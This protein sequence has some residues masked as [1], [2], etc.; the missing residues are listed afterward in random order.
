MTGSRDGSIGL[1]KLDN[2]TINEGIK[3]RQ[4]KTEN[5]SDSHTSNDLTGFQDMTY[6]SH[7]E[8]VTCKEGKKIRSIL[9][10]EQEGDIV[11]LTLNS[12]IN[13]F[14]AHSMTQKSSTV[15]PHQ[16]RSSQGDNLCLAHY[17]DGKL[18]AVGSKTH[19]DLIDYRTSYSNSKRISFPQPSIGVRSLSC[20]G[21]I[22]T[23]ATGCGCV[24]FYD[25]K[26][27]KILETDQRSDEKDMKSQPVVVSTSKGFVERDDEYYAYYIN[28]ME[29]LPAIY[30]HCYDSSGT[31]LFV[32]GGPLSAS[33][34]GNYAGLWS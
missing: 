27:E 12:R 16:G 14:D 6:V 20:T 9:F 18:Y 7:L 25:L 30:T 32:A 3:Y 17:P 5:S 33:L 1:W 23:F 19:V 11:A 4:E 34:A 21:N 28:N 26:A 22:L 13:V 24:F 2:E 31:R 15:I 10:N 29:Y 8:R